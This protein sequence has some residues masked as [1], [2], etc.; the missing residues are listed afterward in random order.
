VVASADF[1]FLDRLWHSV[2]NKV[3]FQGVASLS[4]PERVLYFLWLASGLIENGGFYYVYQN[5]WMMVDVAWAYD[6]LGLPMPAEACRQSMR[7]FPD[8]KPIEDPIERQ[9]WVASQKT[10]F[11][12]FWERLNPIIWQHDETM[13]LRLAEY[14]RERRSRV[15]DFEVVDSMLVAEF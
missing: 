1:K 6:Q 2:A 11:T 10:S 12:P 8:G 14:I 15:V 4:D 7:V 9:A 3:E 13:E 5:S